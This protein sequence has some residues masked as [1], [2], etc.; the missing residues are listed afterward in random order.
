[1]AT[2][3]N[4]TPA[5]APTNSP[6][7]IS[8]LTIVGGVRLSFRE[9]SGITSYQG[10]GQF[11]PDGELDWIV[12]QDPAN[13][14]NTTK[15]PIQ[16]L[17]GIFLDDHRFKSADGEIDPVA[18]LRRIIL[19]PINLAPLVQRRCIG[20]DYKSM[21]FG[22]CVRRRPGARRGMTM[23]WAIVVMVAMMMLISLTVD[24]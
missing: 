18:P 7:P 16:S 8:G 9:A 23:V 12:A 14:I 15:A 3:G 1:A 22:R 11:G 10:S 20:T 13:G 5:V 19:R 2:G 24:L 4:P 6:S 17:V 21:L